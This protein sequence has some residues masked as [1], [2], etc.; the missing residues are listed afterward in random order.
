MAD[1][2]LP[3]TTILERNDIATSRNGGYVIPVKQ[4]DEPFEQ[5][6]SEHAIFRALAE[7]MGFRDAFDEN[8][9]ERE[10]IAYLYG[11][12]RTAAAQ[13]GDTLPDFD[14]FWQGGPIQI[15]ARQTPLDELGGFFDDPDKHPLRTESGKIVLSSRTMKG[16]GYTEFGYHPNWAEPT[17]WQ[18][19]PLAREFPFH[20][21]SDQP[22]RRLHSQLLAAH[23][24][25]RGRNAQRE[26]IWINGDD[27]RRNGITA[28]DT[29][30]VYNARG[31]CLCTAAVTDNVR[32]GVVKL[33]TGSR[34]LFFDGNDVLRRDIEAGNPNMVTR[35]QGTS[36]LAQ[37][38]SAQ[39]CLVNI[40]RVGG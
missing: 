24:T 15:R 27:A 26:E 34:G 20:L 19:S 28:G 33:S 39:T 9:T 30:R 38:P 18:Q 32:S 31:M 3:S 7:R 25:D 5:S 10:W 36:R 35:D 23:E 16:F 13:D 12:I 21:I 29:I 1:I 17:E 40:E 22:V 37:G 2:V 14:D 4:V 6:R 8:R 11:Q